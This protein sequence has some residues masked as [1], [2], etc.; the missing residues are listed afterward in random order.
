MRTIKWSQ[1]MSLGVAGMD[2][3]HKEFLDNLTELL[4]APDDQF[5]PAFMQLVETVEKGFR[6]EEELMEAIDFPGL[7]EHC[8]QHARVLGALHHVVPQVMSGDIALGREAAEL[9][10]Q[11]FLYHLSTMDTALAFALDTDGADID[12]AA[13][14]QPGDRNRQ[15]YGR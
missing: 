9:L 3:V 8:E 4:T 15:D 2:A 12:P 13:M 1:D 14:R 11:W 6:T 7:H 10:P 5:V